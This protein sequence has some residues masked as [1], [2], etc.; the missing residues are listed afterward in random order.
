MSLTTILILMFVFFL[1]WGG[2]GYGRVQ[3]GAPWVGGGWSPFGVLVLVLA[4]LYFTGHLH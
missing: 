2:Y 1:F 3:P 4:L